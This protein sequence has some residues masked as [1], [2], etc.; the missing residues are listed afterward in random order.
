MLDVGD[1]LNFVA[2]SDFS[3]V[4]IHEAS[5]EFCVISHLWPRMDSL[6][7]ETDNRKIPRDLTPQNGRDVLF[8]CRTREEPVSSKRSLPIHANQA[9][10]TSYD[11]EH[12]LINA[13]QCVANTTYDEH[14]SVQDD[15]DDLH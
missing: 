3:N 6:T 10:S 8:D 1:H 13:R 14:Q 11:C 7:S 12:P 4:Y 5:E 15:F 9:I 2:Q